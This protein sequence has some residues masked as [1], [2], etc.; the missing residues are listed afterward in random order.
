MADDIQA[1]I[2][3]FGNPYRGIREK[4]DAAKRLRSLGARA[5]DAL[6]EAVDPRHS[7][8]PE[9]DK[10]K[11]DES[12][13]LY[14]ARTLASIGK[15]AAKAVPVLADL[16]ARSPTSMIKREAALALA[17]IGPFSDPAANGDVVYLM[18]GAVNGSNDCW[19]L[20]VR[21]AAAMTLGAYTS[22]AKSAIP[23]L[24]GCLMDRTDR[25]R[26]ACR[27]ALLQMGVAPVPLLLETLASRDRI[28]RDLAQ[29][30][31]IVVG[32]WAKS[33]ELPANEECS[34]VE[35]IFEHGV[36]ILLD[37]APRSPEVQALLQDLANDPNPRVKAFASKLLL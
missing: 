18:T 29:K 22:L 23:T 5:L 37:R 33:F 6:I 3:T 36:Q 24:I 35:G 17:R 25:I 26:A 15:T 2:E 13:Q 20:E 30:G 21:E 34:L 1:L 28:R 16:F 12:R 10:E 8:H 19:H 27:Q 14:A 9:L 11:R 4:E 7:I 31:T 32:T